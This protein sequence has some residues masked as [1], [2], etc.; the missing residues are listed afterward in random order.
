MRALCWVVLLGL[1]APALAQ[2]DAP[3]AA[4]AASPQQDSSV[5]EVLV[6]GRRPANLRVEIERLEIAVY[7]RFNALNSDDEYDIHC[8][9]QAPTGS[10]VPIRTCAPNFVI[11]AEARN[12]T[13]MLRDG[14]TAGTNNNNPAEHEMLMKEKSQKLTEEIKRVASQD[15]QLMRDL[16]RLD[17]LKQLQTNDSRRAKR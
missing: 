14:R 16:M 11:R 10:N 3:P 9:N 13:K 1:G 2:Q 5:D 6:P 17:E 4:S 7:D 15:E 12:A 8:L